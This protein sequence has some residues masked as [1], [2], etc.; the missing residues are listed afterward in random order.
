MKMRQIHG[1]K[2]VL[3]QHAVARPHSSDRFGAHRLDLKQQSQRLTGGQH[4]KKRL[5]HL[6]LDDKQKKAEESNR[7]N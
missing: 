3:G 2:K 7:E 4:F 6:S 1:G 5:S